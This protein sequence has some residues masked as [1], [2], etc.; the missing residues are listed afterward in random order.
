MRTPGPLLLALTS[1]THMHATLHDMCGSP[2]PAFIAFLQPLQP[3]ALHCFMTMQ[4][5][6]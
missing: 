1:L 6:W 5:K 3:L 2:A 4:R